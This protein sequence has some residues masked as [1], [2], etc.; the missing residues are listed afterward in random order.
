MSQLDSCPSCVE[1]HRQNDEVV[2][3]LPEF[4]KGV[5]DQIETRDSENV[6]KDVPWHPL[7]DWGGVFVAEVPNHWI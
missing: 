4:L 6:A 5:E 2:R 1:A 7:A 3:T